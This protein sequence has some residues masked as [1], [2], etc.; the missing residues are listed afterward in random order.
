LPPL[1][2]R[3]MAKS[4]RLAVGGIM[5]ITVDLHTGHVYYLW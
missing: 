5:P 4:S 2:S 3:T 1:T